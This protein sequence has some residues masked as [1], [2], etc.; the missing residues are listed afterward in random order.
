MISKF[1]ILSN[2]I[3]S[4][5][6][7]AAAVMFLLW[8]FRQNVIVGTLSA[9]LLFGASFLYTN[10][11]RTKQRVDDLV[12][13][14]TE[15]LLEAEEN[16]SSQLQLSNLTLSNSEEKLRVTLNSIG[17]AVV[18]TD[19]RA[20]VT[21]LNPVA[22][23]LTGW[24]H[25]QAIG[26]PITEIFN[27][28][29]K[30]TRKPVAIPILETLKNGTVVGL[31]NHTVL[32]SRD[33]S[34]SD[35]ADTCAPIRDRDG[36]MIG[37]VLVFRDVTKEYATQQALNDNSALIQAVLN[38]VVD[39]IIVLRARDRTIEKVNPSAEN[40]FGYA[41][42]ALLGQDLSLLIPGLDQDPH[43]G[44]LDRYIANDQTRSSGLGHELEG[45]CSDGSLLAIEIAVSEL[46][47]GSERYFTVILRDIT[48]RKQLDRIKNEINIELENAKS[49]AEKANLAKSDFLSSMSHELR[50]PLNAILGFAQLIDTGSPTPTELQ[51]S[52]IDQILSAGWYLLELINEVLDLALIESGKLSLSPEPVLLSEVLTSCQAMIEPQAQSRGININFTMPDSPYY[53][54]VDRT[55]IK[56]VLI[57]LLSNAIKYNRIGGDVEVA[58]NTLSENRISISIKDTGEGLEPEKI[59]QLFQPFNRL[60]QEAGVEEGTGIG[61]VVCKRLIKLMDGEIG[62]HSVIGEGSTF[63]IEVSL[64]D[65]PKQ[66]EHDFDFG[67]AKLTL[68]NDQKQ[69]STLLYVEDNPAN[70]LLVEKLLERRSDIRLLSAKNGI[71]GIE[72]ANASLPDVILMDINLPG[73]SGIEAMKIL[74]ADPATAHIP[75]IALSANAMPSDIEKGMQS[76]FFRYLTKPIKV[77]QLME[78]LDIA[79]SHEKPAK[80]P[81]VD[82]ASAGSTDDN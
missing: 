19:T 7:T 77:N 6:L 49:T 73:I 18:A 64:V 60:G 67:A 12:H 82:T 10:H 21:L 81:S 34:E 3:F 45:R 8:A 20:N 25:E 46:M 39:G 80:S 52:S 24:T 17:D 23:Q 37:A 51:K 15:R 1:R 2:F 40:M 47:L 44:T 5:L 72:I 54:Y 32:I 9:C 74:S 29:G 58:V 76:G 33:G 68:I 36:E 75:I 57:N 27:I 26:R 79:L 22:E 62:V 63:W 11:R 53:V 16:T 69:L 14:Q 71:E 65:E 50:T 30:A 56:Q 42:G 59:K 28:I 4:A 48:A 41:A 61:L 35:I 31:G 38:T 78:T 13:V 55:R 66:D 70:L 43:K